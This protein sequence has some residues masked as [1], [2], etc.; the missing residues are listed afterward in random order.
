MEDTP[1]I[2]LI[3][4]LAI[5]GISLFLGILVAFFESGLG[6]FMLV[7]FGLLPNAI[8][9]IPVLVFLKKGLRHGEFSRYPCVPFS[10]VLAV[11]AL[12]IIYGIIRFH[13]IV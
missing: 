2:F 12:Y 5:T 9:A 6:V 10:V 4:S 1:K 13:I 7:L 11:W 8:L 3:A